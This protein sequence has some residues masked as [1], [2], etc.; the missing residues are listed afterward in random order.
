MRR[1][2]DAL[3]QFADVVERQASL[4]RAEVTRANREWLGLHRARRHQSAP[5]RVIDDVLE[6]L[7]GAARRR[8]QLRGD[9]VVMTRDDYHTGRFDWLA[10][11]RLVL[12]EQR[13]ARPRGPLFEAAA[14][15]R[16][17]RHYLIW[18]RFPAIEVEPAPD[19]GSI[20]RFF[21]M[22]YRALGRIP[23]PTVRL[24]PADARGSD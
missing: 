13:V 20:V 19:G 24:E 6:W 17:A 23:G 3:E 7:A 16:D 21:D 22:R 5:Q 14:R 4:E 11:P 18:T 8:L 1:P 12:D 15:Q 2:F 10:T 9:V